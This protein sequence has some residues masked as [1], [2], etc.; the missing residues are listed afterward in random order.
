MYFSTKM[1]TFRDARDALMLA[2]DM[3]LIDNEEL[4]LLYDLNSSKN[5]DVP[6]WRYDNFDLD[7]LTDAECKSEFRFLKHDI[8]TLLEVLNPPGEKIVCENRF[9]VYSDET[10]CMLLRRFAYPRRY[11]D[12]VPRF[13]RAVP[14]SAWL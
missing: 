14:K 7:T 3:T 11:E 10:L 4:L 13:G 5:L 12:L 9:Y 1:A 6:Y 2:N 8:Y